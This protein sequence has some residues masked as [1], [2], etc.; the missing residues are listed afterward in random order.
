[1]AF[2]RAARALPASDKQAHRPTGRGG[3]GAGRSGGCSALGGPDCGG[4]QVH[5]TAIA[6]AAAAAT[7]A[8]PRVLGV[9]DFALKR[10]FTQSSTPSTVTC[11]NSGSG[12]AR[13]SR[14]MVSRDTMTPRACSAAEKRP[15]RPAPTPTQ[16]VLACAASRVFRA[17]RSA[18]PL[19]ARRT[20]GFCTPGSRIS[21]AVRRDRSRP[22]ARSGGQ[23]LEQPPVVS[24]QPGRGL[25]AS[26]QLMGVP[27]VRALISTQPPR[28]ISSST[29]ALVTIKFLV[30][31]DHH[32]AA[33]THVR[34]VTPSRSM[35]SESHAAVRDRGT[36]FAPEPHALG[37]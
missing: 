16:A 27:R 3:Q 13:I 18:K 4:V 11:A 14:I 32:G 5:G 6:H 23:V 29:A 24:V 9:D 31:P 20:S 28:S 17:C 35:P 7:A 21:A 8:A 34:P 1:M 26:R 12:R 2:P 30:E 33:R 25:P 10:R 19:R 37:R 36:H 15:G 22:G